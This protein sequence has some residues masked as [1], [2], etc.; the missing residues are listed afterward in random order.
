M[1][2]V[3]NDTN[4]AFIY[5]EEPT[6]ITLSNKD[7]T[8]TIT[9]EIDDRLS[10]ETYKIDYDKHIIYID[11]IKAY[12]LGY[13]EF[14]NN[15]NAVV[16]G[17]KVLDKDGVDITGQTSKNIGTSFKLVN[18]AETYTVALIGDINRD[19]KISLADVANLLN[20]VSGNTELNEAQILAGRIRKTSAPKT[21]DVAKLFNFVTSQINE[22]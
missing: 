20:Y 16:I 1:I 5:G 22:L 2:F 11:S 17:H 9:V 3:D 15:L 10:S 13:E 7:T 18:G 14:M 19:G 21:G 6:Q 4:R 8:T 12:K